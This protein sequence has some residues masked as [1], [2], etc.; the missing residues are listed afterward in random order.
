MRTVK[1]NPFLSG[2]CAVLGGAVVWT[3]IARA[4][5]TTTNP[6]AIVVFP[7]VLVSQI[8]AP[9]PNIDT[10]IQLTN[11]A[12][13]RCTGGANAGS[14][15]TAN[16]DCPPSTGTP[17]TTGTCAGTPVSVRCFLVNANGHCTNDPTII[18]NPDDN[19]VVNVCGPFGSC[20]ATW[21]E[22]DFAFTLSPSQPTFW[23]VG[24]GRLDLGVPPAPENPMRG[25]L[26]C[27]EVDSNG[28][29]VDTNDLKG[30]ATI[31]AVSTAPTVDM[32]GYN[33]IGIEA[34]AGANDNDNTLV[35]GQ[36][37]DPCPN[38]LVVDHFFDDAVDPVTG[39]TIRSQLTLVPCSEDFN[40]QAPITTTVQYL[41]FNEFEQRFSTS[42]PLTCFSERPLSDI[43][44]KAGPGD[45]QVSIFNVNV[46]GTLTG[47]TLVRGVADDAT[48]YGH[49]L[50]GVTEEFH[51]VGT[52]A[53]F[54]PLFSA[55]TNTD[56][57]GARTQNDFIYLPPASPPGP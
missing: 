12:P 7:K 55:A 16:A 8:A 15:C 47:Q 57:R 1:W 52:L 35:L 40:F 24:L 27:V 48:T 43:D 6:A 34:I 3:S 41:V 19:A 33:G 42:R 39:L 18:C 23:T 46:E 49:G 32:R 45:D 5:V 56:Q 50:L 20:Q 38:V 30:E 14:V 29:P 13:S 4:D 53:T 2:A 10:V 21:V 9:G 36:E 26:K 37:Y 54:V 11:T 25:E 17:P 31:E 44:T 28:K 51:G 22:T